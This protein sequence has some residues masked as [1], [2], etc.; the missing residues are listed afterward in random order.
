MV[1]LRLGANMVTTDTP[2]EVLF[3][4]ASTLTNQVFKRQPDVYG[5]YLGLRQQ[6]LLLPLLS[7]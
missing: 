4:G 1:H 2:G 3:T 5:A 7:S 6:H